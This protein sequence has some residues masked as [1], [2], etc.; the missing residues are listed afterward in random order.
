M[1]KNIS[2][3]CASAISATLE[4]KKSLISAHLHIYK[5]AKVENAGYINQEIIRQCNL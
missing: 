1:W 2:L 3:V 4:K 5:Y